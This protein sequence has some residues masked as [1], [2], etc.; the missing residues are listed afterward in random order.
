MEVGRMCVK[1]AGRE[2][3]K[4]CV[5]VDL[6]DENFVLVCGPEVKRRKCNVRH[7][8]QLGKR[9]EIKKGASDAD[10]AKVMGVQFKERKPAKELPKQETKRVVKPA[11]EEKKKPVEQKKEPAEKKPAAEKKEH[12]AKE[13]KK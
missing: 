1:L 13:A 4:K 3:G 9:F 10:I 8:Q 6:V 11:K 5:I 12:K 7:L 2:T